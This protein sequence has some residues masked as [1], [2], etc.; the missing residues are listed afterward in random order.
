MRANARSVDDVEQ[1]V[2]PDDRA[3]GII[4]SLVG[5]GTRMNRLGWRLAGCAALLVAAVG[6]VACGSSTSGGGHGDAGHE[7]GDATTEGSTGEGSSSGGDS[8]TGEAS[9]GTDDASTD[10]GGL[11]SDDGGSG[12]TDGSGS[13]DVACTPA[14]GCPSGY[15]CGRYVDPCSGAAFVCGA[16]CTGGKVCVTGGGTQTCQTSSCAGRCGI[17]GTDSCGVPLN[18]GGCGA[19][20]ACVNNTCMLQYFLDAS[21]TC[22]APTCTPDTT[23][24][25]CGTVA[26]ACG[27]TVACSCPAGQQCTGGVCGPPPPECES[28]DGGTLRCGNVPNA[29]GSGNI[30][31]A[32]CPTGTQCSS[33]GTCVSC[34]APVCGTATCGTAQNGCGT[35]VSCGPAWR[36]QPGVQRG[37][38]L[39]P[40]HLRRRLRRRP[41]DRMR[42]G[43]P[44]LRGEGR[45][46]VLRRRRGVQRQRLRGVRA[47]DLRGAPFGG[48]GLRAQGRLRPRRRRRS[49]AARREPPA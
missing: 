36:D 2:L 29:C 16:A 21:V 20:K 33:A 6:G 49:T 25:L 7:P 23:T 24:H 42:A 8:A 11:G 37:R 5:H 28:A 48:R 14:T 12:V 13:V 39:H 9:S 47:Q 46:R 4:L 15:Q 34:P 19:G 22:A 38:L 32:A 40:L 43:R 35:S 10:D 1:S 44:G 26:N 17:V 41:R 30:R 45:V 27:T 31:C 18:C 3:R